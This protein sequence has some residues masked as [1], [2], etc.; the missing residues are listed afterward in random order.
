MA[1]GTAFRAFFAALG[2]GEAAKRIEQALSGPAIDSKPAAEAKPTPKPKKPARSDAITLLSTLQREARLLDLVQES[3][4]GFSDAQVG[5]AA[6]DVLRDSR[7]TLDRMFA[8]E[9]L[10]EV[11]EGGKL[12]VDAS[13]SPNLVRLSGAGQGE[14]TVV[15]RGWKATQCAIP[16][17]SGRSDEALILA[18]TEVE[19]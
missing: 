6:R 9:P 8:V 2:G 5:A 7:A 12:A 17:W 18:P 15:H 1:I 11:D 13:A 4:D 16:T 10:C 3:L 19:T 14:G